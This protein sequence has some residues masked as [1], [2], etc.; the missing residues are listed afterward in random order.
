MIKLKESVEKLEAY[1]VKDVAYRVKLDANEWSNYLIKDGFNIESF[2]PNLY[3]DSDSKKL[4]EKMSAYY[5]CK[6]ENIIVG[7]GSSEIINTGK[8]L[9]R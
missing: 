2:S 9:K 6:T 5:G 8:I 3:P 7:N 1:L 4:R